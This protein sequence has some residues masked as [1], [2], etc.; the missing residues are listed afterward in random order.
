[1]LNILKG[2]RNA[3]RLLYAHIFLQPLGGQKQAGGGST[4]RSKA[5]QKVHKR[6]DL[7]TAPRRTPKRY[8]N[9]ETCA[10]QM[11]GEALWCLRYY[12]QRALFVDILLMLSIAG[13]MTLICGNL[14]SMIAAAFDIHLNQIA[15]LMVLQPSLSTLCSAQFV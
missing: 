4:L 11:L 15:A 6:A 13:V 7:P 3:R 9:L 14:R 2:K 12:V 8:R 10:Q 5:G 1:M